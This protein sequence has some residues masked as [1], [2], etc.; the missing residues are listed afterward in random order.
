MIRLLLASLPRRRVGYESGINRRVAIEADQYA[1]VIDA[2]DDGRTYTL[3]SI[4][5]REAILCAPDKTMGIVAAV[6]P[7]SHHLAFVVQA[8]RLGED[9]TGRI[10]SGHLAEVQ[11]EP[12]VDS[13]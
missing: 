4:D 3:G 10:Q 9:G 7:L 6:H 12:M 1:I 5:S 13:V 2:I 11:Q 8:K